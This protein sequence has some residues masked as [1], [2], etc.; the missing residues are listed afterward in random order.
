MTKKC[1]KPT[2]ALY[3]KRYV[4][5]IAVI[6][7]F[8]GLLFGFDTGVISG[9]LL[10]IKKDP[11]LLLN[12]VDVLSGRQQEWIVSIT[13]LGAAIGAIFSGRISDKLGRKKVLII[14]GIIFSIGS[15]GLATANSVIALIIWRF[16]IGVGIGVASYTVPLYISEISPKQVRGA[17]VSINQLAITIGVFL[18]Y[19]VD[20]SL[21]NYDE[22]WRWMFLAGLIPSLI[23]TIGMCFLSETPRWLMNN[24]GEEQAKKVLDKIGE[25]NKEE[26]LQKIKNTIRKEKE[27][28]SSIKLLLKSW[29]RPALII[30]I[31]IHV[32]S[33]FVG[34]NTITYYAPTIFEMA[35]FGADS[36]NPVYSAILPSLPLGFLNILFTVV[37]IMLVDRW[38]RKPLLYMGLIGMFVSLFILG[39]GFTFY[40][41]I[42]IATVKWLSFTSMMI[43]ISSFAISI[44]PVAWLLISEVFPIKIRGFGMSIATLMNWVSNFIIT[45]T[46]LSL[47]RVT[48]GEM[49]NPSGEGILVNPGGAFFIYAGICILGIIFTYQYIPETKGHSLEDIESHFM[50]GKHPREL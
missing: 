18:S 23:L 41:S 29:V 20:L 12:H 14:A 38:G 3:N 43:Y 30:G 19:L 9:A 32:L 15:I 49:P 10:L 11:N 26:V 48:T 42:G 1:N 6:A 25:S 4:I 13:V 40:N 35:G 8:G 28:I 22:G 36:A 5:L 27:Q 44:G 47:G 37:S 7:A 2:T 17:L 24:K 33:Q 34:I 21:V 39:I 46:F 50:A 45:N 31:G 16:F